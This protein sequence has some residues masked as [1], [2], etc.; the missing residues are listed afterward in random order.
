MFCITVNTIC[1][2][3]ILNIYDQKFDSFSKFEN[4]NPM[5]IST[6]NFKKLGNT[7]LLEHVK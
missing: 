1:I 3:K 2:V 7:D 5:F 4:F 6:L